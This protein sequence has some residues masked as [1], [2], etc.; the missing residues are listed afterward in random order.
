LDLE[1]FT[2]LPWVTKVSSILKMAH[3][4]EDGESRFG[5]HRFN[6]ESR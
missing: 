5:R 6:L 1:N 2:L 3:Y 4:L